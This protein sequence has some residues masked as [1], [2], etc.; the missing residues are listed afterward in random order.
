MLFDARASHDEMTWALIDFAAWCLN[1]GN[2]A[3]TIVGNFAAVQYFHRVEAG[4]EID[5]IFSVDQLRA[6]K[7]R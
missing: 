3:S 6:P 7:D 4:I 1:S 2:L 5:K